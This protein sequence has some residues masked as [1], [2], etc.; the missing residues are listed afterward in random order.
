[1]ESE[2]CSVAFNDR[3]HLWQLPS[4]VKVTD[5][6]RHATRRSMQCGESGSISPQC[7]RR[8][9]GSSVGSHQQPPSASPRHPRPLATRRSRRPREILQEPEHVPDALVESR[10]LPG[11]RKIEDHQPRL[12]RPLISARAAPAKTSTDLTSSRLE[13]VNKS[14]QVN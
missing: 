7:Q 6:A 8:P 13:P 5:L 12:V 1:M 11:E 14:N 9:S 4:L 10:V 2:G 3:G